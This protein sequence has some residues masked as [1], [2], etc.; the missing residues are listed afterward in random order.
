MI[1]EGAVIT[2]EI[3]SVKCINAD[4]DDDKFLSCAIEGEAD[5]VVSGDEHLL[6]IKH[7]KGI[8]IVNSAAF[9]KILV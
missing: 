2:E 7:Y 9:V 4:P 3:I 5:Y 8:Q 6:S 1:A